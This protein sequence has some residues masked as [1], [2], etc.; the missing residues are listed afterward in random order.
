MEIREMRSLALLAEHGNLQIV[1]RELGLSP[2]TVHQHLKQ[3]QQE[4]AAVLYEKR[5]G[6]LALTEA[7]EMIF[8]LLKQILSQHDAVRAAAL[9][10]KG[11]ARGLVRIGAGPSFSSYLLPP[12][13]KRFRRRHPGVELFV[14]TGASGH[15]L[16]RLRGGALDLVF[17]LAA[18]ALDDSAFELVGMWRS[19]AAFIARPEDAPSP[20]KLKSLQKMP[21]ILFQKGSRM[22]ALVSSYLDGLNFRPKVVMRSDSAEAIKAMIR[23]GLGISVLFVWNINPDLRSRSLQIVRTEAQPLVLRMALIRRQGTPVYGAVQDFVLIATT[24]KWPNLHPDRP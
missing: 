1:A 12:L 20:A 7:G 13:I 15:L 4:L 8:P 2:A 18:S 16:E 9:D 14:E 23:A 21:F 22:E 17:D 5:G 24:M 10:W 3:L 19:E 6:R 11:A